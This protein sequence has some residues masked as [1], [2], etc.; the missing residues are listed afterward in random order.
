MRAPSD[1]NEG[2]I[3][4]KESRKEG[5][6]GGEELA[7]RCYSKEALERSRESS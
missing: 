7:L 2:L 6:S 4:M 3:P 5:G 1:V